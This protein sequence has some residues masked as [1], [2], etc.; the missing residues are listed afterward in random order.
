MC[1]TNSYLLNISKLACNWEG[2]ICDPS[3]RATVVSIHIP[4]TDFFGTIP[5]ELGKLQSLKSI[6]L[7]K[8]QVIGTIPKEVARLSNLEEIDLGLNKIIGTIPEFTSPMLKKIILDGNEMEGPLPDISKSPPFKIMQDFNVMGNHLTG[9]IPPS[10]FEQMPRLTSITLSN[11]DLSGTIPDELGD[12][13][14]LQFLY[15]DNNKLM[16]YIP[17]TLAKSFNG[18]RQSMNILREVWLQ[19]N[20]LSGTIPPS[21]ASLDHLEDFYVDG[22]KLTGEI[23]ADLCRVSLNQ[24]FFEG[25]DERKI[26]NQCD[27]VACPAGTSAEDGVYP[28]NPCI[29]KRYNPY[30]G[31]KGQCTVLNQRVILDNFYKSS[32]VG[33]KWK[34]DNNWGRDDV[35]ICDYSGVTCDENNRVIRLELPDRGLSGEI[36]PELGFLEHLQVLDLSSNELSGFLPSDL[37]WAP[38]EK[39]DIA[40]NNIQG[41]VPPTLCLKSGI[42]GNG[43]KGDYNCKNIACPAGMYNAIGRETSSVPCVPCVEINNMIIGKTSCDPRNPLS[44]DSPSPGAIIFLMIL[45]SLS[46]GILTFSLCRKYELDYQNGVKQS[47]KDSERDAMMDQ[48]VASIGLRRNNNAGSSLPHPDEIKGNARKPRILKNQIVNQYSSRFGGKMPPPPDPLYIGT[49]PDM[50]DSASTLSTGSGSHKSLKSKG[51][52]RKKYESVPDSEIDVVNHDANSKQ[53]GKDDGMTRISSRTFQDAAKEGDEEAKGAW[54][55]VPKID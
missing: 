1:V 6:N 11:N 26:K 41:I 49:F 24:D 3:D 46:L 17:S 10:L 34:G 25:V 13:K 48:Y 42:N 15:L 12:L 32:S 50:E 53:S 30:L 29:S 37:R 16:G 54:L 40:G 7:R 38:L 20:T 4:G 35:F 45:F 28:C 51:S 22:N 5:S 21:F 44:G 14:F 2:I 47:Q 36:T 31:S 19:N 55:D 33:G 18:N 52:R 9:T 23:P 43:D 27:A 8:N 39:L